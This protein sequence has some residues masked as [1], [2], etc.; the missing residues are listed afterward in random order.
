VRSGA[1][2]FDAANPK[3]RFE[4]GFSALGGPIAAY[5]GV[6]GEAPQKGLSGGGLL[7]MGVAY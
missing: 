6:N 4:L 3:L 1:G 2:T 5:S 7:A